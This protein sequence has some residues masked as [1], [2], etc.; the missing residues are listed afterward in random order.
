MSCVVSL[1]VEVS[2]GGVPHLDFRRTVQVPDALPVA[3]VA[4]REPD[5]MSRQEG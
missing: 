4:Y 1:D 5:V 3:Y 2:F